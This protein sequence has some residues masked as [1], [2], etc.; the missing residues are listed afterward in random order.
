MDWGLGN[1]N[2]T[3]ALIAMLMVAVWWLNSLRRWGFWVALALFTGMGICLIHTFSRG[4]L[5]AMFAGL[6][7][8]IRGA[9]GAWPRRC[10]IGVTISTLTLLLATV[11]LKAHERCSPKVLQTD[12]S[13]TNRIELWKI[14]PRMMVDAP[15]G[16]GLGNSGRAYMQWY[17]SVNRSE[18]Y[19]TMVSS[20]LTWLVE[21]GWPMRFLYVLSLAIVFLICWP[22][23]GGT[24]RTIALGVWVAFA[25]AAVFSTVAESP[26][27]W[28]V[29]IASLAAALWDRVK[30][31]QWPK[32]LWWSFPAGV[33][34]V[35]NVVFILCGSTRS[36]VQGSPVRVI[37]GW[38]EPLTWLVADST[39][40]GR[41]YGKVFRRHS[42]PSP[43]GFVE[44]LEALDNVSGKTVIISGTLTSEDKTRLNQVTAAASKVV[45]L[46]PSI[47]PFEVSVS[48]QHSNNFE[49]I[50]GEFS[51]SP[52]LSC[53]AERLQIKYITNAGDYLPHWPEILLCASSLNATSKQ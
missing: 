27:L 34:V 2:K 8:V 25:T 23:P 26:W 38:G 30:H 52:A 35:T 36:E 9:R 43:V 7:V 39:I 49:V 32:P 15:T 10:I 45:L 22:T 12:R 18:Q 14:A 48:K 41:Y 47:L 33:A 21:F 53:W 50:F 3:A 11:C 40:V 37:V 6:L 31:R 46:N 13:I 16:W 1:P 4:G 19:R 44:S 5:F 51:Q 17:Q 28:V 29:P 42:S 20:H 24:V